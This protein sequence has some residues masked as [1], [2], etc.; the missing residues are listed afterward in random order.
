MAPLDLTGM[1]FGRL[2]AKEVK[3]ING[4]RKWLCVCD[5]G[6][7]TITTAS[8]LTNGRTQSCGCLRRERTSQACKKDYTGR[9]FGRLKVLERISQMGEST[10]YSCLC[11]CGNYVEVSGSN[12]VTGATR[13]CGCLRSEETSKNWTKHG[14]CGDRLYKTWC[15]MLD[16][17]RNSKNKEYSRYGGRGISVCKEWASDY[18]AFRVW[19]LTTG[20]TD[21]MTIDRIDV[22]KGY[23]PSNCQWLTKYDHIQKSIRERKERKNN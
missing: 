17:C 22:D 21:E 23:E 14:G 4:C 9:T 16:R 6:N 7:T 15:N 13:S 10:K 2:V 1:R 5:C 11:S 19:A 3:Q 20:Y 12:L 18:A 8:K